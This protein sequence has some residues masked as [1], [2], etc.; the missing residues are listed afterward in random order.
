MNKIPFEKTKISHMFFKDLSNDVEFNFE[1][2]LVVG[3]FAPLTMGHINLIN[4][5]ATACRKLTVALCYDDK[6]L[7]NQSPRDKKVLTLKNRM[8]WLKQTFA[9]M[10]HIKIVM[11]DETNLP[12]YPNGWAG[13]ANLLRGIYKDNVIPEGT[14][15]FSSEI[16]Y[17]KGYETNVSELTHVIVDNNRNEVP[18]S[19]T[20]VREN[21]YQNWHLIPSCVRQAYALKV[22]VIGTE[23]SGK[24]TLIKAMVKLFNT[25]WVEEYGRNYCLTKVGGDEKLLSSID[26]E[27]IAFAHK[28]EEEKAL[29][30]ANKLSFIDSNAFVT[31]FYHRLYEGYKNTVVTSIAANEEYD[32]VIYMTDETT[33]VD[34]GLRVNGGSRS[35]TKELFEDMLEEFPNQKAKLV[36]ISGKNI[37]SR[38]SQALKE[39]NKLMDNY[40]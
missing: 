4:K 19:A 13:Y 11:I 31:E 18:I 37:R 7:N 40:I 10:P 32:L 12:V 33:W 3:K 27:K 1:E 30:T 6:F 28:A 29:S 2:G 8:I 20:M 17:I 21:L 35:E 25:S 14:A 15:I 39:I 24:S 34:D 9:D 26:Y 22:C 23:S 16:E 38:H 36:R 5:A